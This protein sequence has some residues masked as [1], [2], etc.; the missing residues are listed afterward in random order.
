MKRII[1]PNESDVCIGECAFA[2]NSVVDCDGKP[3]VVDTEALVFCSGI[4]DVVFDEQGKAKVDRKTIS[5]D[6]TIAA[7]VK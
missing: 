3:T 4:C 1:L 7:E 6:I 5:F 2:I